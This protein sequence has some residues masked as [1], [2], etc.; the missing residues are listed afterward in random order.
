MKDIPPKVL[1]TFERIKRSEEGCIELKRIKGRF[2]V[3]R[4]TS[5]WDRENKRVRKITTY[6]GSITPEGTYIQKKQRV[7]ES[8][9]EVF[10]YGNGMLAYHFIRDLEEKLEVYT[11]SYRELIATQSSKL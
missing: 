3:Y 7:Q 5:E 9:R 2:Y 10:E 6:L 4:A 11:T 1:R 8:K